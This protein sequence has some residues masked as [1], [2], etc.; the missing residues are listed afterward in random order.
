MIQDIKKVQNELETRFISQTEIVD[1]TALKLLETNKDE[2]IKF[3][4]DYTVNTGNY[5]VTRWEKLFQFLLLKFMDG[6]VK[7]E[8][9]RGGFKYNEY[10]YC[11][12][13]VSNPEYPDWWKKNVIEATGNKLEVPEGAASH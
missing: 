4:T 12:A 9:G 7:Q 1:Q 6:N 13:P 3:L 10:N 11:P 8:D 2:A 5:V